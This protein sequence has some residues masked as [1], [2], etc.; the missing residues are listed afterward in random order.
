MENVGIQ[1]TALSRTARSGDPTLAPEAAVVDPL[2]L[3]AEFVRIAGTRDQE[4][5]PIVPDGSKPPTIGGVTIN[6]SPEDLAAA[7]LVL[8]GKTQDAQIKTAQKGLEISKAKLD[9]QNARAMNK[10]QEWIKASA[11]A[12]SKEKVSSV[13][14]WFAKAGAFLGAVFGVIAAA[15]ATVATG[16][17]A[18]PLLAMAVLGVVG[19]GLSL[20]SA[21]SQQLGGPALDVNSLMTKMCSAILTAVGVPADKIEAASKVMAG[22]LAVLVPALM[23]A[24]PSLMGDL[25][26]GIAQL[27][28]ADATT[29]AIVGA[30]FAALATVAVM[31]VTIVASG[32][33]ALGK[34]VD[35]VS[36]VVLACSKVAQA[37]VGLASGAAS[38]VGGGY[39]IAAAY[40][41]RTAATAQA[42]KKVFDA[43]IVKLGKQMEEDREDLKK[44]LQ[45]IMDG[46]SAVS[47]MISAGTDSRMQIARAMGNGSTV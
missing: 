47:Q 2:K 36:E 12:A 11:D 15:V 14:D 41:E 17:A 26:G 8:Q 38:A 37:V 7:L 10:I 6:F 20:A 28:G 34:A 33:A 13:T 22:A 5:L 25:A 4:T 44:V 24:D 1:S 27:S 30:V 42:D 32:G 45:E 9:D 21:I 23:A 35:A 40:D 3:V 43:V 31:G 18:A 19:A 39:K 16:G 46:A 29:A